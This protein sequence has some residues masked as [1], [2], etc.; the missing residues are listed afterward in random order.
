MSSESVHQNSGL[1]KVSPRF[2]FF[3]FR[4]WIHGSPGPLGRPCGHAKRPSSAQNGGA[5]LLTQPFHPERVG[6]FR[7][8]PGELLDVFQETGKTPRLGPQRQEKV[9]HNSFVVS[10][11]QA[12]TT[13]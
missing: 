13:G 7:D 12:G 1:Q 5:A 4:A 11:A 8:A 10:F 9:C 3:P 2:P 6:F